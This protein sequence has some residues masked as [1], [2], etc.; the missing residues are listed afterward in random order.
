VSEEYFFHRSAAEP[1]P[2]RKI[3]DRKIRPDSIPIF[4][5]P[6]FL[7]GFGHQ[8]GKQAMLFTRAEEHRQ[9]NRR[10]VSP[11]NKTASRHY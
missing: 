9:P 1:Q 10:S 11:K 6:I 3:G 2:D 5:S 8:N 4:L 7:S